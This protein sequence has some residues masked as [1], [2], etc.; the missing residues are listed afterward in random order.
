MS[1]LTVE[2]AYA[3][4]NA[5]YANKELFALTVTLL[6]TLAQAVKAKMQTREAIVLLLN[7]L[8]DEEKLT[9]QGQFKAATIAKIDQVAEIAKVGGTAVDEVKRTIADVNRGGLKVGSHKG[10]PVYLEDVSRV[11]SQLGAAL[12]LLRGILRR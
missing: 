9:P 11:G 3:L 10:K 2:N 6:V 12:S 4:L 7:V 1:Y 8:K 5:I